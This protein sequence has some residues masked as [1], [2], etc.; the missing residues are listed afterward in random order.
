[1]LLINRG[2]LA[3]YHPKNVNI[4]ITAGRS[5]RLGLVASMALCGTVL[6]QTNPPRPHIT[7]DAPLFDFGV[8]PN[9]AEVDHN[10]EIR[11]IGD[12]PLVIAQVRS[13]CGCTRAVLD[14]NTIEPGNHAV[15]STRLNLRGV[16]GLKRANI[17]LHTNDPEKPV[18]Q[19]Q[20]SGTAVADL[21]VTPLQIVFTYSPL[22]HPT[23]QRIVLTGQTASTARITAMEAQGS[24]FKAVIETNTP[25]YGTIMVTPSSNAPSGPQQG[26]VI[27]STDHPRFPRL[28][29][30]IQS[31]VVRDLNA[32]PAEIVFDTT[33][34]DTH[35]V[36]YV[37]LSR[38][39]D[40]P[41]NVTNVVVTPPLF[42]ARIHSMKPS[43]ARLKVGPVLSDGVNSGAVIR[44]ITDSPGVAPLD[45]PV[46]MP[47]RQF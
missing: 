2:C 5:A 42:P 7:C 33:V 8:K 38:H 17:Y 3:P 18:F 19:C 20:L 34:P 29:V 14:Q 40:Q 23:A 30:P 9:S 45:I 13:G 10:F 32:Y 6:G 41:F 36:R 11:N 25:G 12:A 37:V 39:D 16:V 26:M 43:W 24:F 27:I 1:M 44:V 31:S 46:R 4:L 28:T 21:S 35:N 15:L 47:T 22:T